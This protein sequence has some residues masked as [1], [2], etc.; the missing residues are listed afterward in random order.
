MRD[1]FSRGGE[2]RR[3]GE[4]V[5]YEMTFCGSREEVGNSRARHGS[6]ITFLEEEG[7]ILLWQGYGMPLRDGRRD[8]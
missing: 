3:A 4:G 6:E 8:G 1:G 5:G 2:E 7:K